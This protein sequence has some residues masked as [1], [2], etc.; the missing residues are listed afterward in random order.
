MFDTHVH[1]NFS[2][3]KKNLEEVISRAH[4]SGVHEMVVPGTDLKTSQKAVEI[5]ARF[6][7]IY[8]AVGL[9]PHHVYEQKDST[10][11]DLPWGELEQLLPHP[12]VVAIGEV[13][14]DR[15]PY[16]ETKYE[17]YTVDESFI[18]LQKDNLRRQI[19]WAIRYKKSLILHNR[20][21]KQDLFPL[22]EEV[23]DESLSGRS[24]FHCCEADTELLHFAKKHNLFIGVDGDISY[25][26]A[27]K[28]FI[29]E[30]PLEML[31]LETDAPFLLP[32]P[33]RSQRAYP[34]EPKNIP[35]IAQIVAEVKGLPVK[36]IEKTTTENAHRLFGLSPKN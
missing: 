15:H 11:A 21:A 18:D 17:N 19:G 1:L 29:K 27:K 23:W 35:L 13:G 10:A 4:A 34:N 30:V 28:S 14:L 26:E 31:V 25:G 2:R 33:L 12:K 36:E 6:E 16:E 24:V 9:H 20:E 8:A 3:F 7:G 5:A 22:L 32:E